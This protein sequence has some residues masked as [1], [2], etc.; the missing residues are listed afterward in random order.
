MRK[1]ILMLVVFIVLGLASTAF[2]AEG[3]Y[4]K[5]FGGLGILADSTL[6]E[7]GFT[8]VEMESDAGFN[9]GGAVGYGIGMARI[10][11]EVAYRLNSLD[12]FSSMGLSVPGDGDFEAVSFMA[13]AYLDII[14]SGNISPYIGGGIGAATV[15]IE[16]ASIAGI[17]LENVDDTVFAGQV[18]VG[19]GFSVA[20]NVIIDGEYRFFITSDWDVQ[21]SKAEYM[22]HGFNV[23]VRYMF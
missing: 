14:P 21:T 18:M 5:V 16:D 13:N 1:S 15:S 22:H 12:A 6:S 19:V 2:A 4:V 8:D 10:E 3:M 11:G 17:P 23:G 9:F 20:P 7:P